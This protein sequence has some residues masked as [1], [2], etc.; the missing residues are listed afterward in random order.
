MESLIQGG[1]LI[2]RKDDGSVDGGNYMSMDIS[3]V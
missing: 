3:C 2:A 1:D